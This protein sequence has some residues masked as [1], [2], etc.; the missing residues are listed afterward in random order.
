MVSGVILLRAVAVRR[1]H[2]VSLYTLVLYSP[3]LGD[4]F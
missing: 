3:S 4:L 1:K 2:A